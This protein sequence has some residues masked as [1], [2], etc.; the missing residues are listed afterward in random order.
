MVLIRVGLLVSLKESPRA[1]ASSRRVCAKYPLH[2]NASMI[3]SYRA[4][5]KRAVGGALRIK[6]TY[7]VEP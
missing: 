3:F 6:I 1:L 2:P 7:T 4:E 5:G